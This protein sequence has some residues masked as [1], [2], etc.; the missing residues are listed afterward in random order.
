VKYLPW[1]LAGLLAAALIW[2]LLAGSG[3]GSVGVVNLVRVV[4]ESPRAQELNELLAQRYQELLTRFDLE[5]A[6]SEEDV[7][8]AARERQ[9][10]GEYLAY[11]Q[12]LELQLEKEVNAAVREVA[13]D[14]GISVVL[15]SDVIRYGGIDLTDEVIRKLK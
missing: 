1:A 12:E 14:K 6:P 5:E 9:A 11:R 2:A 4:D 15:D 3:G 8:R 10:Y 7:D 13:E